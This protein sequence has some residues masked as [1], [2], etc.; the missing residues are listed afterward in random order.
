MHVVHVEEVALV[1]PGLAEDLRPLGRR[2]DLHAQAAQ[3]EGALAGGGLAAGVDD[4]PGVALPAQQQLLAV[5]GHGE[6]GDARGH[7]LGLAVLQLVAVQGQ[8]RLVG[9]VLGVEE[10]PRLARGQVAVGPRRHV[11]GQ[12]ALVQAGEVDL[13]RGGFGGVGLVLVLAVVLHDRG[14]VIALGRQRRGRRRVQHRQVDGV[15]QGPVEGAHVQPAHVQAVVGAGQ[16][17]EV[18]AVAVPGRRVAVGQAVGDLGGLAVGQRLDEDR[19]ELVGQPPAVGDPLRVGRPRRV[20]Q[21][22]GMGEALVVDQPGLARFDVHH[23]QVAVGIAEGQVLRVGGPQRACS[24]RSDP[25]GR[26]SAAP[27]RTGRRSPAGTR[28]PR[29]RTR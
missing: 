19:V 11:E 21:P 10:H 3:V 7:G 4:L 9:H 28:R 27:V 6:D 17:V 13:H 14:L 22:L 18:L 29:R 8:A 5:A 16:E 15:V 12:D 26:W 25:P 23:P 1:A 24:R 20:D 2:I